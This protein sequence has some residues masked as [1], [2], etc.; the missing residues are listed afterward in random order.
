MV[1]RPPETG[2]LSG[3]HRKNYG[4]SQVFMGKSTIHAHFV[5]LPEGKSHEITMKSPFSTVKS[6]FSPFSLGGNHG[7]SPFTRG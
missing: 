3:K 2:I 1:S 4:K 5:C 7:K 6:P